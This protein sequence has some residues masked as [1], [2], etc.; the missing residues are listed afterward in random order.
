MAEFDLRARELCGLSLHLPM[1][2]APPVSSLP[3]SVGTKTR[4]VK[5]HDTLQWVPTLLPASVRKALSCHD[6]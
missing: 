5:T 2:F 6:V 4:D 3:D 1:L